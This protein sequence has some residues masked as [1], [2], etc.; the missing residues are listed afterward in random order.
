MLREVAT[1]F[2]PSNPPDRFMVSRCCYQ[3]R[4]LLQ[5]RVETLVGS[6]AEFEIRNKI[7]IHFLSDITIL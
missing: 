6:Q 3:T 1:L 7:R 5:N 4:A 2:S